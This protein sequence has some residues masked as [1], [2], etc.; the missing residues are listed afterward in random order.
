MTNV[1]C[2]VLCCVSSQGPALLTLMGIERLD[3]RQRAKST[4]RLMVVG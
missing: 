3:E 2:V 4:D 1:C